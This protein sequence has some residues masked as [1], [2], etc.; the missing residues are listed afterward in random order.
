MNR[1]HKMITKDCIGCGEEFTIPAN[2]YA[3]N[4]KL[5]C[6]DKCK[7]DKKAVEKREQKRKKYIEIIMSL[8]E[9]INFR[10]AEKIFNE[11]F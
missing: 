5:Y 2:S 6:K 8:D 4:R 3:G 1:E 10:S 11:F 7:R 9:S